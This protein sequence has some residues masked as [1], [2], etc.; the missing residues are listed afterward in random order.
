M[1]LSNSFSKKILAHQQGQ[2][3]YQ[4]ADTSSKD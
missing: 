1:N 4:E 2:K 3:R